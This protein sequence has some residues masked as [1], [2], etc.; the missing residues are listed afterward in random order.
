MW[1][2]AIWEGS[3]SFTALWCKFLDLREPSF[4]T[5]FVFKHALSLFK[6]VLL[7]RERQTQRDSRSNLGVVT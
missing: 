5:L 7:E 4:V 3:V 1:E 2:G 6:I